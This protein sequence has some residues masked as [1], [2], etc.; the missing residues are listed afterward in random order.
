MPQRLKKIVS[1]L[2]I[3][4]LLL[5]LTGYHW[6]FRLQQSYMRSS[7][8]SKL[9]QNL[10]E[11]H[12]ESIWSITWPV[13]Q[14]PPDL[15]WM[16]EDEV[17]FHGHMYDV[18]R[19]DTANGIV[20]LHSVSDEDETQLMAHYHHLMKGQ[21]GKPHSKKARLWLQFAGLNWWLQESTDTASL[22]GI[23]Q[24]PQAGFYQYAINPFCAD[25]PTP[26]PQAE[27]IFA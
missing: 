13:E 2:L 1:I 19:M 15:H 27:C 18:L 17:Q 12:A 6:Y 20:T 25:I 4:T 14:P 11:G 24:R 26:P 10:Q 3:G 9:R 16:E 23:P 5:Q 22:Y 8:R 21:F 7:V